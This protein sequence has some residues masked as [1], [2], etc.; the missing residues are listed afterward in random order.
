MTSTRS[1]HRRVETRRKIGRKREKVVIVRTEGRREVRGPGWR[2]ID[3][4]SY[5]WVTERTTNIKDSR[6]FF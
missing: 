4:L 1:K 6:V 5:P 3:E 2:V